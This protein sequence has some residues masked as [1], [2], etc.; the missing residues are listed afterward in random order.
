MSGICSALP[1]ALVTV[2]VRTRVDA[3]LGV[4]TEDFWAA[5]VFVDASPQPFAA[6]SRGT[7]INSAAMA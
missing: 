2:G 4:S 6:N 5:S 3:P 1:E 7:K